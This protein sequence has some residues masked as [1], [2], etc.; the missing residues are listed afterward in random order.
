MDWFF[1][2]VDFFRFFL[3]VE[4]DFFL[5]WFFVNVNF[6]WIGY[7]SLNFFGVGLECVE[8]VS[9]EDR[10]RPSAGEVDPTRKG[11]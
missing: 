3:R 8:C 7:L 4:I 1:E 9:M 11:S 2:N 5:D 10:R 6:F